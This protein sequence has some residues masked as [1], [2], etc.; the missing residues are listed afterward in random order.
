MVAEYYDIRL[1]DCGTSPRTFIESLQ[2]LCPACCAHGSGSPWTL[3]MRSRTAASAQRASS[4]WCVVQVQITLQA[5]LCGMQQRGLRGRRLLLVQTLA[6]PC[7]CDAEGVCRPV[8]TFLKE[9]HTVDGEGPRRWRQIRTT[10]V[11]T[12]TSMLRCGSEHR[13]EHGLVALITHG[14]T[15]LRVD[16]RLANHNVCTLISTASIAVCLEYKYIGSH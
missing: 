4:G 2:S 13:A 1:S 7:R 10:I 9:P 14:R 3:R 12:S 5:C 15:A 16:H 11:R 8:W 6:R